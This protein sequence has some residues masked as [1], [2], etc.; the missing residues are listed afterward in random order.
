MPDIMET[1]VMTLAH[2][3]VPV[4]LQIPG[5]VPGQPRVLLV[6]VVRI[7]HLPPLLRVR[8]VPPLPTP[9][10]SNAPLVPIKKL[11]LVTQGIMDLPVMLFVKHVLLV[12]L[13]IL[14]Q[15]PGQPR[16]LLVPLVRIRYL[17]TLLRVR[18][19]VLDPL[20]ILGPV[21]AHQRVLFVSL[22]CIQ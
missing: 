20:Q 17:P 19:A 22:A 2:C 6:L 7:H 15:V 14:G 18:P 3:V 5:Q 10:L 13:R 12:P 9:P 21:P 8:P 1:L 16:V 11:P 4:P